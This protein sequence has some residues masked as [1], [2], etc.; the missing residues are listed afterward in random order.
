MVAIIKFDIHPFLALFVGAIVYGFLAGMPGDLILQS[1]TD[2]FGGVIGKIGLV[3][4]LGVIIGTFLEKTGGALVIAQKVLSWIGER[5]VMLSMMITGWILSIPVFADSAFVILSSISKSLSFKSKTSFAATTI[6]L[7]LGVTSSHSLVPPT[8]GPIAAAGIIGADLGSVI[9]WGLLVSSVALIPCFFFAKHYASRFHLEP[10]I[11]IV[12]VEGKS[13][14]PAFIK[15]FLP[16]LFPLLLIILSSIASYPTEPF[17]NNVF[18][19]SIK[20]I[21]NPVIALTIGAF[22][23]FTLPEKF[24]RQLLSST[25]WVGESLLSAAPIIL[26]TG[27]GGVFGMMLQNSG[28]AELVSQNLDAANWGI[29]L[30]FIMAFALKTA[31]GSSTVALITTASVIAPLLGT[32]GLDSEYMRV[33]TVL[34][35]GAGATSISHA[36][37][38]FFWVLTQMTG[39]NI[40]LGNQTHSLGTIV[41][42]FTA[43]GL[44]YIMTLFA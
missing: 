34:A 20:F 42:S 41:L 3:I 29:F 36:N 37:D 19:S 28:I 23:S 15:S 40:K 10:K 5:S 38:S 2:G 13:S 33:L 6:A 8:P 44:I 21:G 24:D 31:Q 11:M 17:G 18:V 7:S 9:M 4:L 35:I 22:I 43:I 32:L 27:A 26:I 1:I 25:G 14:Q 39:M 30:P 12:E 16:I